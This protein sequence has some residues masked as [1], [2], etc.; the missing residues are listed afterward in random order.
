MLLEP[1]GLPVVF[2][3]HSRVE[4]TPKP[5]GDFCKVAVAVCAHPVGSK[6]AQLAAVAVAVVEA[7]PIEV[8]L[9]ETV[10]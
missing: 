2:H 8:A 4:T 7:L 1:E 3:S 10:W 6:V 5:P 9:V